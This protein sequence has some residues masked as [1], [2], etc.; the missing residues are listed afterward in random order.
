MGGRKKGLK[1]E[2]SH[3]F[4]KLPIIMQVSYWRTSGSTV[5]W[6]VGCLSILAIPVLQLGHKYC[7][8]F[9]LSLVCHENRVINPLNLELCG[10]WILQKTF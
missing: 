9:S 2:N 1:S 5:R 6:S 3:F 4:D 8:L 10:Q 7:T